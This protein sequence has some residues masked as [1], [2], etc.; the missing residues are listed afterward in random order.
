MLCRCKE[1]PVRFLISWWVSCKT[2]D[3]SQGSVATHLRCGVIFSENIITTFLLILIVKEFWKSVNVWWRLGVPKQ[4]C[5]FSRPLGIALVPIEIWVED[6]TDMNFEE[7][8]TSYKEVT[9]NSDAS[10]KNLKSE[11]K[12]INYKA[13][14]KSRRKNLK[15][16]RK[17]SMQSTSE[18]CFKTQQRVATNGETCSLRLHNS[19]RCI[20]VI[21]SFPLP[22]YSTLQSAP[23]KQLV[24]F[25][26]QAYG[27]TPW[28]IKNVLLCFRL[29]L[30]SFFRD[31][32]FC[33]SGKR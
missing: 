1:V 33:T 18:S 31:C 4:L 14:E 7:K 6:K 15:V 28:A 25:R 10:S 11:S 30:R 8:I 26:S 19:D 24:C 17:M 29:E 21:S 9:E 22:F 5:H 23:H 32:T 20:D 16:C 27:T 13:V 3:I 2:L 12:K